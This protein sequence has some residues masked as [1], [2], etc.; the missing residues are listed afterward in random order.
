M[1]NE[2]NAMENPKVLREEHNDKCCENCK[3]CHGKK[4]DFSCN[5]QNTIYGI[6]LIG[7][8]IYFITNAHGF[9]AAVLGILKAL[10]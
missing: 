2:N 6:G 10:V 1:E 4:M 9:T 7:A 3:C 5:N 8:L